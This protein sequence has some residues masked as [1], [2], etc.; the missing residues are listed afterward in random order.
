MKEFK[1]KVEV[2]LKP[3]VLDPQGK[4]VLTAL[5]NLGYEKVEDARIGKLI[6]LKIMDSD[7]GNVRELVNDMCKKLLSNPVIE[8]FV[9]KV[10]E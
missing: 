6:E 8:D 7:A 1:V 5:H 10:E 4:T 2:K 3:V 9:V